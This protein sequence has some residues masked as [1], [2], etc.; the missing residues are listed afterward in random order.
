MLSSVQQLWRKIELN[1]CRCVTLGF[2]AEPR[3]RFRTSPPPDF[4]CR[5]ELRQDPTLLPTYQ[6]RTK[7]HP[8]NA[9]ASSKVKSEIDSAFIV[10]SVVNAV[11]LRG[12]PHSL[13]FPCRKPLRSHIEGNISS[14]TLATALP[15]GSTKESMFAFASYR[16]VISVVT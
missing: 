1:K 10:L 5:E 12:M 13:N 3:N 14:A 16:Y 11:R 4:Y 2:L 6:A 9:I 8:T 7:S 15:S